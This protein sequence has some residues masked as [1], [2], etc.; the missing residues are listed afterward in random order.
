MDHPYPE[1]SVVIPVYNEAAC[2][3][4]LLARTTTA[5]DR[6]GRRFEIVAVDDGSSDD[7]VA[8]LIRIQ[9][10][11]P[12]LR[13]VR[14]IRNFGQTPA[15][16]AGFANARGAVVVTIDADLQNP[17]EEIH[18]V[19]TKLDE[20]YDMAQGW[21]EQRQDPLYR[22]ICS[23]ALNGVVSRLTGVRLK[24]LGCGLKAY[25]RE[26]IEHMTRFGHHARYVPAEAVWLGAKIGEVKVEHAERL[27]GESKYTLLSLLQL[28]FNMITSVSTAPIKLVGLA[29][30]LLVLAGLATGGAVLFGAVMTGGCNPIWALTALIFFLAGVQMTATG[31]MCEYIG[32]IYVEVQ[33]KPYY[34]IRD[35]LEDNGTE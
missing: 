29:G 2:L 26:M 34:V 23:R 8:I 1:I 9:A 15:V 35:V 25:R 12:R 24:D 20:G 16:Y 7:S 11:E 31:F 30:W 13:I 10:T 27:A 22:R 18:K 21:R 33:N 17:P 19:V 32:R 28:N 14:L 3:D 4:E 5:M 6:L